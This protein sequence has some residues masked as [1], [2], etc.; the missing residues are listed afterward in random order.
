MSVR[1]A[2]ARPEGVDD[3]MG[4]VRVYAQS[5][6]PEHQKAALRFTDAFLA[7]PAGLDQE[8]RERMLEHFD[9]AQIVELTF[10]LVYWSCNKPLVAA[11]MD[12]AAD[13]STLTSFH[14]DDR[15]AFIL[16]L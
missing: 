7:H 3:L 15:G 8:A 14:Y 12:G 9:D 13:Q 6:L 11:G 10:K 4:E 1:R 2:V 5:G 16:H